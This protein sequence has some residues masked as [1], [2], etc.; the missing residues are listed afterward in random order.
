LPSRKGTILSTLAWVLFVLQIIVCFFFYDSAGLD[1]ILYIGWIL[2]AVG[3]LLSWRARAALERTGE[4]PEGGRRRHSAVLVDSGVYGVVRHPQHLCFVLIILA[5]IFISQYWLSVVFGCSLIAL[6]HYLVLEE[7][8]SNV[9][10]FGS[11]YKR[12]MQ[13]VP[14]MNFLSGIV[15]M[16]KLRKRG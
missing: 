4:T 1:V 10:K 16:L 2:L 14:R 7:E 8:K 3:I 12:Y 15:R 11:E 6:H 9:Q 13:R 5:L